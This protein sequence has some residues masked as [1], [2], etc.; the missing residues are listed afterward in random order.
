MIILD[1]G[2]ESN[3]GKNY[4]YL[5]FVPDLLQTRK[6][7]RKTTCIFTPIDWQIIKDDIA[8]NNYYLKA[9]PLNSN[10]QKIKLE[11]LNN[12]IKNVFSGTHD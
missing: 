4:Y 11:G 6:Y 7:Q 8:K 5:D 12:T 2:L 3:V 9:S 10:V 1:F